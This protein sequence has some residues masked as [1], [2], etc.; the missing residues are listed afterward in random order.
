METE[1]RWLR[2][3]AGL[4]LGTAVAVIILI[5]AGVFDPKPV[6]K[7]ADEWLL[8]PQTI[9]AGS[10][11]IVWL[12]PLTPTDNYSLRLKAT[13]QSGETDVL[14]GSVIGSEDDYWV[15]AVSPLGYAALWEQHSA[16][17]IQHLPFQPWPHVRPDANE[18]WL[19]MVN[20]RATIY[21][22]RELY[23]TG[24]VETSQGRIGLW[25]ESFG[26]TAVIN[27]QQLQLTAE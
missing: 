26:G 12:D 8:S 10:Q 18:I 23:W 3:I 11:Q 9:A 27:F 5:A 24:P 20:G 17:S 7:L 1:A 6:G 2:W 22:N 19:E 15:T 4:V 14:Y 16:S 25:L 21:L 13:Y